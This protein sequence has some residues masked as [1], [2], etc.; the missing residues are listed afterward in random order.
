MQ[1]ASRFA[2]VGCA[3]MVTK[4][5]GGCEKVRIGFTGVS[6]V[7]F[8]DSKVEAALTGK[9]PTEENVKAA[10]ALAAQDV[11]IMSDHFAS[12]EYRQHLARVFAE[13]A[14]MGAI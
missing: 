4:G 8:R 5:Q 14:L 1:P 3:A 2:I 10:A 13:R 12:E 9:A 7:A 11:S 6:E